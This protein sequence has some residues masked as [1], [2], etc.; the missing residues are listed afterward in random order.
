MKWEGYDDPKDRTWEAE[1]NMF[2]AALL[3]TRLRLT[4]AGREPLM[5]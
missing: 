1:E 2:V 5:C 3:C 4:V